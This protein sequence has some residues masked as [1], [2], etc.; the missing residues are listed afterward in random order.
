MFPCAI[1]VIFS[2]KGVGKKYIWKSEKAVYLERRS[3]DNILANWNDKLDQE[4]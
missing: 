3:R 1:T 4:V 2:T